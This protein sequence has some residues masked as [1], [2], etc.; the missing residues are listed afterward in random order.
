MTIELALCIL[1]AVLAL[2]MSK[3]IAA[4][5]V[6]FAGANLSLLG[7][8]YADTSIL[9]LVFVLLAVA[10]AMIF[11]WGGRAILLLSAAASAALAIESMLGMDWLLTRVT[12]LSA[13]VNAAFAIYLAREYWIWTNGK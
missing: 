7:H 6:L 8:E 9:A 3:S 12:Y 2:P 4:H 1:F 5:Y 10:D 11:M 13:V